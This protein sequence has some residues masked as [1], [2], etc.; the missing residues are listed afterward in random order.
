MQLPCSY[1]AITP[2]I[3]LL[4][5]GFCAHEILLAVT[6]DKEPKR[7]DKEFMMTGVMKKKQELMKKDRELAQMDRDMKVLLMKKDRE[8]AQMDRDM[9]ELRLRTDELIALKTRLLEEDLEIQRA[10][11]EAATSSLKVR[12][13]VFNS[14]I[15]Q[16]SIVACDKIVICLLL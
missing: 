7:E 6:L 11:I 5:T 10:K 2:L 4:P 3:R 12:E 13:D 8:L 15:L 9:K 1:K 16:F 14:F